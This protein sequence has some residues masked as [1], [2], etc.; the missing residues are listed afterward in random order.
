MNEDNRKILSI[1][2]LLKVFQKAL[3]SLIPFAEEVEIPWSENTYDNWERIEESL[4]ISI[5]AEPIDYAFEGQGYFPIGPYGAALSDF[6]RKSF[7]V[8]E[9]GSENLM[10]IGL[11]T[12]ERPFD[13]AVFMEYDLVSFIPTGDDRQISMNNLHVSAMVRSANDTKLLVEVPL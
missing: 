8:L 1:D 9:D 6:S 12:V 5:V 7:I 10:F 11:E 3:I 2:S 4:F 13:T